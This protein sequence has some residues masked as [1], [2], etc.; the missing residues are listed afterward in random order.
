[1]KTRPDDDRLTLKPVPFQKTMAPASEVR[2]ISASHASA[3][4]T[5]VELQ[6]LPL[7]SLYKVM[8]GADVNCA[9]YDGISPLSSAEASVKHLL[10]LPT[11]DVSSFRKDR[12]VL[13]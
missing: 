3:L 10:V 7:C 1:M 12:H 2:P 4:L 11:V 8:A 13:N 9:D 5:D 6:T